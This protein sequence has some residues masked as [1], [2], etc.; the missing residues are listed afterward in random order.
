MA[1]SGS[2]PDTGLWSSDQNI[3]ITIM[4]EN[5]DAFS[6]ELNYLTK[7]EVIVCTIDKNGLLNRIKEL[8]SLIKFHVC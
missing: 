1:K 2:S 7:W 6:K 5:I 4:K 3:E 8:R